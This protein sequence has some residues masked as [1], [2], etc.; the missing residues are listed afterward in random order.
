M[1]AQVS[2][3]PS[4]VLQV[5]VGPVHAALF[6]AE[7][8]PQAPVG[9]QAGAEPPHCASLVHATQRCVGRSQTGVVPRHCAL[10]VHATQTP[11]AASQTGVAPPQRLAF[12]AEQ[13]PQAPVGSQAGAA[14]PH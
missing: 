2:Q 14:P 3:I 7:Q 1:V 5:D 6:V 12:V 13:G 10:L 4:V 11:A 9:S 8:T